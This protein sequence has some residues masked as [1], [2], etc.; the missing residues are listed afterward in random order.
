MF[1]ASAGV[2]ALRKV[3]ERNPGNEMT[4]LRQNTGSIG[5]PARGAKVC[6]KKTFGVREHIR[7]TAI[8]AGA[9]CALERHNSLVGNPKS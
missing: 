2:T 3:P 4:L 8:G 6:G 1:R 9:G 7:K 5:L